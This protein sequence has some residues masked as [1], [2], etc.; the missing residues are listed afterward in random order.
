C[1]SLPR[2]NL[3]YA[4][5]LHYPKYSNRKNSGF[6]RRLKHTGLILDAKLTLHLLRKF[7]Q[8]YI[9]RDFDQLLKKYMDDIIL[10]AV[11]NIRDVLGEQSVSETDLNKFRQ[12]L[13]RR[14]SLSVN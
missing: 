6:E 14:V 13:I 5:V 2:F 10:L 3:R 12:S 11:N 4:N 8:P 9:N 1:N 7:L